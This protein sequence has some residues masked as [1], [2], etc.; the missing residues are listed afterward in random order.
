MELGYSLGLMEEN[1]KASIKQTK[2]MATEY[3]N[4]QMDENTRDSGKM[5]NSME[6]ENGEVL[7]DFVRNF[8]IK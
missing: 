1:T 2:K 4:G 6:M 5:E 7:G 3:L 8:R